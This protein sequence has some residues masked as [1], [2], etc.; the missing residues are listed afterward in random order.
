MVLSTVWAQNYDPLG[1]VWLSA[2]IALIPIVFFLVSLGVLGWKAHIAGG[3]TTLIAMVIAVAVFGMPVPAV[4][5]AAIDGFLYGLWPIAWIIIAAVFLYKLSVNSGQFEIIR[6]SIL[7]ITADQRILV[8]LV[9][10]CFGAFLEGAAGFGAPVAI[11]AA[12]LVG[13]G[14]K[15]LY[16]AGLCM[17]LNT[18]PV[19]F[20]ALGIPIITAGQVS[21]V[22]PVLV[23]QMAGHQLPLMAFWLPLFVVFLMDGKRG[24]KETWPAAVVAGVT[25]AVTQFFSARYLGPQLPDITSAIVTLVVTAL[26]LKKWQPSH[27]LTVEEAA[28]ESGDTSAKTKLVEAKHHSAG[29]IVRAWSPFI[30]LVIFIAIW[31]NAG[32]KAIFAAADPVKGTPAGPLA[33]A[34]LK[35]NI[36]GLHEMVAQSEPIGSNLLSAVFKLDIINSTGTAIFLAAL[37]GAAVYHMQGKMIAE[38]LKET[39]S[40]MKWSVVSIGCVLAFAYVMNFSGM[41][42]TMALALSHTGHF[43][44]FVAPIIGWI[45]VFLTGSDTSSNAL[46]CNLQAITAQQI[47]VS[48]VLM[49]TVNT[50]GGVTGKMISPQSI[51]IACAAVGMVGKE[52]QLLRFTLKYS[53][54]FCLLICILTYLQAYHFT[55]MIPS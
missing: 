25:F 12:L 40:E 49:V 52:A 41:A 38:T 35:F 44:P 46:F 4:V 42:S 43:F 53:I 39:V 33:S 51:S 26:F 32:F 37:A 36:P 10:F 14:L 47:G 6:D 17:I 50:T 30:L 16:A 28:A 34:V 29:E 1:N 15:P 55:W 23:G 5:A 19:A 7:S 3:T 18:A 21:G 24:V 31:T 27:V 13:I 45:G 8:I 11:T 22:D 54:F 20:G 2:L 48:D 9:G